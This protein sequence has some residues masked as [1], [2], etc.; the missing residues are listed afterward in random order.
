MN[1]ETISSQV[2]APAAI[3]VVSQSLDWIPHC[4]NEKPK[5]ITSVGVAWARTTSFKN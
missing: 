4:S 5:D 2:L 1:Q 3:V